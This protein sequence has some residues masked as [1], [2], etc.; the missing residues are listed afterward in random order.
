M[1]AIEFTA[2][3]MLGCISG[4]FMGVIVASR[5]PTCRETMVKRQS[6]FA[7]LLMPLPANSSRCNQEVGAFPTSYIPTTTTTTEMTD[8]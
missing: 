7:E 3:W 2:T 4:F 5:R 1:A 8:D 6:T